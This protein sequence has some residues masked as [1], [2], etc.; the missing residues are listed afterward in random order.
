[1]TSTKKVIESDRWIITKILNGGNIVRIDAETRN[2]I[3]DG[4]NRF[5]KWVSRK[6][7]DTLLADRYG[8]KSSDMNVYRY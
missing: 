2:I 3:A 4:Q 5:S 6:Y 1:M 8:K 7:A